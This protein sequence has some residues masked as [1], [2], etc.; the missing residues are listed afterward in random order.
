MQ[1]ERSTPTAIAKVG[2]SFITGIIMS[3][4]HANLYIKLLMAMVA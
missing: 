4:S 2:Y 3:L 1:K